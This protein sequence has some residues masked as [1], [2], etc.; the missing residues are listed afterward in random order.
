MIY[1]V[2]RITETSSTTIDYVV[3]LLDPDFGDWPVF[4]SGLSYHER[5]LSKFSVN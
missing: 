3:S 5:V 2:S 4:I 1:K